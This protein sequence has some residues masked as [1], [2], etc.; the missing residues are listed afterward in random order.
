MLTF[1]NI[2]QFRASNPDSVNLSLA[3]KLERV[4]VK[5][6]P[7]FQRLSTRKGA[8]KRSQQPCIY[9]NKTTVGSHDPRE[10]T[11]AQLS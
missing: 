6:D 1:K 11:P 3:R 2:A 7:P 10:R 4:P 8:R 5:L 9:R